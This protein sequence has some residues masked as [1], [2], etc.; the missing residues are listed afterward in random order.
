MTIIVTGGAGII[1]SNYS[2]HMLEAH[3]D[4]R[5]VYL[6][7][8]IYVGNLTTLKYVMEKS[9][10]RFVKLTSE[11]GRAFISILRNKSRTSS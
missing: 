1:G 8:L 5:I 3:P 11:T 4:Y 2:F 7:K 6:D 10:F 9:S